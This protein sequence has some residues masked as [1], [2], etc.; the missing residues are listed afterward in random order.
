MLDVM[1]YCYAK[2]RHA[3]CY[4]TERHGTLWQKIESNPLNSSQKQ[5]FFNLIKIQFPAEA[6]LSRNEP[7]S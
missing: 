5:F 3:E 1:I 6:A 7:I 2:C 4:S